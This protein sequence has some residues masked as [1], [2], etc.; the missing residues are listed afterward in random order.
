MSALFKFRCDV[1][2][3]KLSVPDG[4]HGQKFRCPTCRTRTRVPGPPPPELLAGELVRFHCD[5]CG[6][7]LSCERTAAGQTVDCPVCL[8]ELIVPGSDTVPA[9]A[10]LT[11]P[12]PDR[13]PL[14][15]A[16]A[17]NRSSHENGNSQKTV[18]RNGQKT[19]KNG[20][21]NPKRRLVA[22]RGGADDTVGPAL[23]SRPDH[24]SRQARPTNGP[25]LK[26]LRQLGFEVEPFYLACQDRT[27]H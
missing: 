2:G 1:C 24:S 5:H 16:P 22:K 23:A 25:L 17:T 8:A 15:N 10:T 9:K 4:L 6:Q 19:R 11:G 26:S 3:Q 7:K 18:F 14:D 27:H 20:S 13:V 21:M 12:A